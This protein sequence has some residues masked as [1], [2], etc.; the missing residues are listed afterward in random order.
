MQSI[1]LTLRFIYIAF[2]LSIHSHPILSTSHKHSFAKTVKHIHYARTLVVSKAI[3]KYQPIHSDDYHQSHH[4]NCYLYSLNLKPYGGRPQSGDPGTLLIAQPE[5]K[6]Q[7]KLIDV[8]MTSMN[9]SE[10][11]SALTKL[12]IADGA[13]PIDQLGDS[14]LSMPCRHII[15]IYHF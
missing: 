12:I 8:A 10:A 13:V 3:P 15:G 2:I 14:E 9:E 6:D 4:T 5:F 11:C 1:S 7:S